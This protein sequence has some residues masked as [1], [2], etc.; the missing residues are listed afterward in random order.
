VAEDGI[1]KLEEPAFGSAYYE[2]LSK[3]YDFYGDEPV[4]FLRAEVAAERMAKEWFYIPAFVLLFLLILMQRRRATQ[5][6][7]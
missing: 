7:F 1:A 4:Q 2:K 5:P 3:Q 6:A